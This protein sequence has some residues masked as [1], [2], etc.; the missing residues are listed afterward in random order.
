M[1]I[2]NL[3]YLKQFGKTYKTLIAKMAPNRCFTKSTNSNL[4]NLCDIDL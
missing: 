2:G 3:W 1:W 4:L